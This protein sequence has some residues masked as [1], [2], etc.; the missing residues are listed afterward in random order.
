MLKRAAHHVSDCW[1]RHCRE[2]FGCG[3]HPLRTESEACRRTHESERGCAPCVGVCELTYA[4]NRDV[5]PVPG[6]DT[7]EAGCAAVGAV[8]LADTGD[9]SE[10]LQDLTQ[11]DV[12]DGCTCGIQ[13]VVDA[14]EQ[15]REE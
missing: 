14:I 13:P 2:R 4:R 8:P 15:E 3:A 7:G 9:P 6:C 12:A 1:H 11:R 10:H 5:Q